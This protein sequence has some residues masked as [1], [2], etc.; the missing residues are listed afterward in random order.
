MS[1]GVRN[2]QRLGHLVTYQD[3]QLRDSEHAHTV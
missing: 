1:I 2:H 3:K